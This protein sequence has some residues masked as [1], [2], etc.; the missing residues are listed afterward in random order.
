MN[1]QFLR[2]GAILGALSVALG[3]FAAHGLK[4]HLSVYALEIF[5]KGVTY[6]FYH[7]LAIIATGIIWQQFPNKQIRLA[8]ICFITGIIL[9]SGSLYLMASLIG[10]GD[11]V[12]LP[13]GIITPFGGVS[14]ILGW[15]F[16]FIGVSKKQAL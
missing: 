13:I 9:F 15:I 16:L 12:G 4:E 1:K 5:G 2:T 10:K 11:S 6:Q 7:T 14:F 8:F 3:A